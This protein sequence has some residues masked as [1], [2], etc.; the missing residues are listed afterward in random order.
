MKELDI[1]DQ[2]DD[3]TLAINVQATLESLSKRK[4]EYEEHM[5]KL[6]ESGENEV[7]LT[8]PDSIPHSG[9]CKGVR[10][11]LERLALGSLLWLW[12]RPVGWPRLVI[13]C[14]LLALTVTW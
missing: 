9:R 10:S 1:N 8:D 13:G 3:A 7:S 5:K 14:S 12:R 11:F 4:Q 2:N 6:E